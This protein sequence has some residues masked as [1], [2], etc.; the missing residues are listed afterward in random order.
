MRNK[1]TR[2]TT[3]IRM[4]EGILANEE[5]QADDMKTLPGTIGEEEKRRE[6]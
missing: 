6:Q 5:G 1:D 3:G 4:M 2:L